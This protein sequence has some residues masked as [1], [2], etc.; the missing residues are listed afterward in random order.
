MCTTGPNHWRLW[1]IKEGALTML[2]ISHRLPQDRIYTEHT[3][4][5]DD[6]LVAGTSLG[7]MTVM[8]NLEVKQR[9]ASVWVADEK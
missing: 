3:W 4:L 6:R 1:K 9:I 8:Q 5:D 2:P 7:E